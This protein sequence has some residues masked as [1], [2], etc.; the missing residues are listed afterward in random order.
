MQLRLPLISPGDED[1][2][3]FPVRSGQTTLFTS[4]DFALHKEEAWAVANIDVEIGPIKNTNIKLVNDFNWLIMDFFNL[5]SGNMLQPGNILSWNVWLDK[6]GPVDQEEWWEHAE[7]WRDSIDQEHE[8]GN[9][10][11]PR[12]FDGT[13]FDPVE[14]LVEEKIQEIIKWIEDH[15]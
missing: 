9:A 12:Y 8:H 15:L 10:T 5:A 13:P 4:P 3:V 14:Q 7:K 2:P 1:E 6:P 11:I